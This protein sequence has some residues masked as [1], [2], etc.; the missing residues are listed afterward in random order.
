DA[1][2]NPE[3]PEMG[4]RKVP[5]SQVIYIEQEDFMET[6]P[7]GYFRLSPGKEVRLK[8][9]YYVKCE[10]IVKDEQTGAVVEVHCTYDPTS[11]GGWTNDGRKV[12]GTLHWVSARHALDAEVRLYDNLFLTDTETTGEEETEEKTGKSAEYNPNSRVVLT[13]C[14]VEPSLAA[15][16]AG[17][18]YQFL[19]Q[20]YFVVDPDTQPGCLVFNRTVGLK[21]SWAKKA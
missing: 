16:Q 1:E 5:F 19:R 21:D 13:G 18:R 3:N 20:G 14:K 7:K 6:P 8:H 10:T 4:T 2:I 11:R 12:K 15:T 17:T 9:A